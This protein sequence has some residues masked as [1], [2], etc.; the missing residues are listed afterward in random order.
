[1]DSD[2]IARVMQAHR[3]YTLQTALQIYKRL[4]KEGISWEEYEEWLKE[5]QTSGQIP[6]SPVIPAPEEVRR[7]LERYGLTWDDIL[8]WLDETNK[9]RKSIGHEAVESAAKLCP[10]C[11]ILDPMIEVPM[12]QSEVNTTNCNQVGGDWK[13]IWNCPSCGHYELDMTDM[14]LT[15]TAKPKQRKRNL[16]VSRQ[17]S[18]I[19]SPNSV[20]MLYY[21]KRRMR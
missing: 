4:K 12:M 10:E 11:L 15:R 14:P 9:R 8:Y 13:T 5:L 21:R 7:K 20:R 1:M 16:P 18:R 19:V 3:L 6:T 17:S 2:K